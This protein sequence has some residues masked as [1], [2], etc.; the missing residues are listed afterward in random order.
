MLEELLGTYRFVHLAFQEFLAARYLAEVER[1]IGQIAAFLE[2]GPVL[3]SWW[4]EAAL[5]VPG[6]LAVTSEASAL[7]LL[8]RLAG[9]DA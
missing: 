4:R 6:Y 7:S 2:A 1:D 9:V 3:D 5:L 8:Q